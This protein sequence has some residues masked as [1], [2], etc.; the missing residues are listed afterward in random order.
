MLVWMDVV[1][2]I[3]LLLL[4][5]FMALFPFA[6]NIRPRGKE[7]WWLVACVE[8][9]AITV[10]G[11]IISHF[12]DGPIWYLSPLQFA[13]TVCGIIFVFLLDRNAQKNE[14]EDRERY[15]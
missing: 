12:G 8:C 7:A 2:L 15:R 11:S 3:V 1:R 14:Y 9:M 5:I 6:L 13:G 4:A 10:A